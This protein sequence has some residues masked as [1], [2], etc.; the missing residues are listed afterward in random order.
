MNLL[1]I[2]VHD[3]LADPADNVSRSDM[4]P[5]LCKDI[6]ASIEV[7]GLMQPVTVRKSDNPESLYRYEL[8]MG[9]RRFT[10]VAVNLGQSEIKAFLVDCTKEEAR[11][12]NLTENLQRK[13]LSFWEE[14]RGLGLAFPEGT[15]YATIAA[16]LGYS[17]TWVRNR[18][19]LMSMPIEIQQQAE[20]GLLGAAEVGIILQQEE[21]DRI[22]VANKLRAGKKAGKTIKDLQRT[23]TKRKNYRSKSECKKMMTKCMERGSMDAVHALRYASG[24]IS[25][26]LLLDLLDNP[27][28][29]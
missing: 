19:S 9:F 17:E 11:I 25:D 27:E 4:S 3:I 21:K 24:E 5:E 13:D 26:T 28:Q 16:A 15:K 10:A 20:A 6:A 12:M 14:A 29:I 2:P 18:Y 8:V 7:N 1:T 22:K 23:L